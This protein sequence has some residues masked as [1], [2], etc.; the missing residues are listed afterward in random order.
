MH[1]DDILRTDFFSAA[2]F[3]PKFTVFEAKKL[4]FFN[5]DVLDFTVLKVSRVN[6]FSFRS[7]AFA[8]MYEQSCFL[9]KIFSSLFYEN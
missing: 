7:V 9:M 8:L 1:D 6:S 5:S 3:L 4:S 2:I